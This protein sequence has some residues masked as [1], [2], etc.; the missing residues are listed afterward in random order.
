MNGVS[1]RMWV[2]TGSPVSRD[3]VKTSLDS[4]SDSFSRYGPAPVSPTGAKLF[5]SIRSKM[6]T[7]R[8]FS[9]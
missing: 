1:D 3:I 6:A 4:A 7:A 5:S 8:S 2:A 9:I